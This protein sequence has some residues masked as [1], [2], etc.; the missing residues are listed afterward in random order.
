VL[1]RVG[2]DLEPESKRPEGS[3]IQICS[4]VVTDHDFSL[5]RKQDF[6]N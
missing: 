4:L 5:L 2:L 3:Q 6:S 1:T